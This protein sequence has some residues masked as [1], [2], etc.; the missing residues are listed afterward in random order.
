[1]DRFH[2]CS[3][4]WKCDKQNNFYSTSNEN[5]KFRQKVDQWLLKAGSG[6]KKHLINKGLFGE[7]SENILELGSDDSCT[8]L[9][10][11]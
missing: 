3:V 5:E 2:E 11:Y 7:V 8:A 10:I 9:W 6:G 4:E 1:M